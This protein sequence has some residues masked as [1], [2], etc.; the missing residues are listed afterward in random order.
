MHVSDFSPK[1][2]QAIT[3]AREAGLVEP[4]ATLEDRGLATSTTSSEWLGEVGEAILQFRSK[5][6]RRLPT[7]VAALLD[8][9]LREIGKVWPKYR[10]GPLNEFLRWMGRLRHSL[11]S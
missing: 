11:H 8:E 1:L 2:R 10:P 6:G 7:E 9:C 3:L 5:A 4:A